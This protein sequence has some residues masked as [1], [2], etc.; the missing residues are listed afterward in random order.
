MLQLIRIIVLAVFDQPG[1]QE[2][3]MGSTPPFCTRSRNSFASSMIVRSALKS[4]SK[5][6][7]N[8]ILLRA[9]PSCLPHR[10]P[11]D[12]RILLPERPAQTE[13]PERPQTSII[14]YCFENIVD[15]ILFVE[16]PCGT[17]GNTLAAADAAGISQPHSERR[18]DKCGKSAVVR[19][20]HAQVCTSRTPRSIFGRE[21]TCCCPGS[22]ELRWYPVHND[23]I[24]PAK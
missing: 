14:S 9:A 24:S 18:A 19:S 16:S 5:T 6:L 1:E 7:S 15:I 17:G 23:F 20:D 12:N 2:V 21:C 11:S 3:I 10:S 13:P 8:P 22:Y 4:V